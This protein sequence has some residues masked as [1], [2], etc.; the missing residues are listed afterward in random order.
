MF[1]LHKQ[2]IHDLYHFLKEANQLRF[3]PVRRLQ[4]QPRYLALLSLP[5]HPTIQVSRPV[6]AEDG[7]EVPDQL[8]SVR[9][10]VL[11]RCPQPPQELL[12][13]LVSGWDNPAAEVEPVKDRNRAGE[14]EEPVT[15]YFEGDAE[16]VE[17][18]QAWQKL[19]GAWAPP[20]ISARA[21][22]SAFESFYD[23]YAALEKDGEQLELLVADGHLAWRT[24]SDHDGTIDISHPVLLKRVELRFDA[25]KPEFTIHETDREPELYGGLFVDLEGVQPVS[26]K[27]RQEELAHSGFHPL[28][29]DDTGAFLKAFIQTVSPLKGIY[30]E[31]PCAPGDVPQ[32]WRAPVLLLR[33]RVSGIANAIDAIIED[34]EQRDVF[35]P[36]LGQITG[37]SEGRWAGGGLGGEAE[38]GSGAGTAAVACPGTEGDDDILLAKESNNEQVQVIKRL[39]HSG[40][41]LVQGP[42]GTGK[43]HTIGNI[44]GHL[45]AHGQS[46]LVTSHTTKALRV[47]RD[48]VPEMLQPLCVSVLGSDG[49]ARKQLES[50]I[51]SITER[52]TRSDAADLLNRAQRMAAERTRL[53]GKVRELG[54]L[55]RTGLENEYREITVDGREFTPSDAARYV[56]QHQGAHSWIPSPVKL[57]EPLNLAAD[58]LTRVYALAN[59]FTVEDE[60]DAGLPLPDLT[61]LPSERQFEVLVTEYDSLT[62][63]DLSFGKDRWAC[64]GEEESEKIAD[65]AALLAS[66]F[67]DDQRRQQWRPHA[68]V[69]GIH[70]GTAREVWDK[71]ITKIEEAC[72]AAARHSLVIHHQAKLS[73]TMTLARQ[74]QVA[75]ELQMHL[76]AGGKLGMLQLMTRSEWRTFIKTTTVAA[77]APCHKDHFDALHRLACLHE[78]RHELGSLW[79]AMIGQVTG[80]SFASLGVSAEQACRALIPEMHRCLEWYE[81]VW[82]PLVGLL[83]AEGLKIDA[84][85]A[86]QPRETSP[87]AEYLMIEHL[88]VEVLPPL[89]ENEAA[90]RRLAECERVFANLVYLSKQADKE[91]PEQGCIGR[92]LVAVRSRNKEGYAAALE[93][94]RHIHVIKPLVEERSGL[95]GRLRLVAPGWA[96]YLA[97]R[98]EPHHGAQVP[99]DASTAWTWRQLHDE[100]V[101]RDKIDVQDIQKQID[102]A[103]HTLRELTV[104]LIDALAWGKQMERLQGNNEVRQ[105]LVGWLDT[106]KR[107]ISTRKA[108]KRQLLLSESRKL[109]KQCAKAVPVWV[110]PISIMAESF[111]PRTTRFDVVIIDEASQADLN[112][113]IPLYMAKQIV[114]VGDHEQVTPLGVGKDQGTLENLRRAILQDIPNAHLYDNLSSIYDIGRQSF[115]DAIRLAEHFRCVPEIIAFSN[116]L[117]YEGSIRPLRETGSSKLKPA[118]VSYRVN[119]CRINMTNAAEAEEIV[120][121]IEAMIRHP[122]YAGKTIGVISMVGD[123]QAVLIET[124]LHKRIA[125]IE[126]QNRRIQAGIS[127]QFQGDERDVI[128]LSFVD[129]HDDEGYLR[130]MGEG[131]YESMK[132]RFNVATSRARDQLWCMHSFDPDRHLKADDMRLKL[133]Q[134]MKNPWAAID[135]YSNEEKKADSDFERLVMK[136]LID[137]GYRVKA[138]WQ[139]G[140]YRIDLVVEGN[141]R[142][143]AIECDGDRYHPLEKLEEDIARQTVLERLGWQ[144]ERIRGSAFYRS[145]DEAMRPVFTRLEELGIPP[146]GQEVEERRDDR[147][148]LLDLENLRIIIGAEK[149]VASDAE[150]MPEVINLVDEPAAAPAPAEAEK[151]GNERDDADQIL[152]VDLHAQSCLDD[153]L[154]AYGGMMD[155]EDLAR[156]WAGLRGYKR[157]GKNIREAFENEVMANE[158]HGSIKVS[159]TSIS[160]EFQSQQGTLRF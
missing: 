72:E 90:R 147:T 106:A 64:T 127:A 160:L 8:V 92:I 71:V 60:H 40:S 128:F 146:V 11:T 153:I 91:H 59:L 102:K 73:D 158:G 157:L 67:S 120:S 112:A 17:L 66:E 131:A 136:R 80:V 86:A 123:Q 149:Y 43:T 46:V 97:S 16:R 54:M 9:R 104:E 23:I 22:M 30:S 25:N 55:R 115:G 61:T 122:A 85:M 32:L 26:I 14:D 96:E 148:L 109:M 21:A 4:D 74:K 114:I 135:A 69:V 45:L 100:L 12:E 151:D 132:K 24:K 65:L 101:E 111:D 129:S 103:R 105:A 76:E 49:D 81:K 20:E 51:S 3:R 144:F 19:R 68:I 110:M 56:A 38:S 7:F 126:I 155:V 113:L 58:D 2:R 116:Q 142:R 130:A 47:L 36:A 6:P 44:I 119:G 53:I 37:T 15:E 84:L 88:A 62:T 33:K 138:Q 150:K 75:V 99:G 94:A 117:S 18:F 1:D 87:I 152:V 42:P 107:L 78:V 134:H 5:Q 124:M 83:K 82:L 154:R 70:G 118:C 29:W 41:V 10:P 27:K 133:L 52:L 63:S 39:D 143:L 93:Y 35:P 141:G 57:G 108:D 137:A 95:I 77:G 159:G 156:A 98:I 79:D 48:K 121:F 34:I 125:S 139:V 28:G 140:Y 13:W 31:E 89:L 145:Q 50:S